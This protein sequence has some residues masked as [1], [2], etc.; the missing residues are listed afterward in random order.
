M[1]QL[2]RCFT[3]ATVPDIVARELPQQPPCRI[4]VS[5]SCGY[6]S[7]AEHQNKEDRTT[8]IER[9]EIAGYYL[10]ILLIHASDFNGDREVEYSLVLIL[11]FH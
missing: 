6:F 4:R 2:S 3:Y 11:E 8:E 9:T 7:I 1:L 10:F 5:T